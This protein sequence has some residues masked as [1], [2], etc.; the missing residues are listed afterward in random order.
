MK[1]DTAA[2]S[3]SETT[4]DMND[5]K[6][7][8]AGLRGLQRETKDDSRVVVRGGTKEVAY[9]SSAGNGAM[10]DGIDMN[11]DRLQRR[12]VVR[13][14]WDK[15]LHLERGWKSQSEWGRERVSIMVCD[16]GVLEP[17]KNPDW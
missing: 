4:A 13:R 14:D 1:D 3:Q 7:M 2:G 11:G 8:K 17:R 6:A 9:E 15:H 16:M 5:P 12:G 10:G